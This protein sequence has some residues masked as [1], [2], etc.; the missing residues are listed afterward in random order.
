MADDG[1]WFEG[2]AIGEG[3]VPLKDIV[4]FLSSVNYKGYLSIEFEGIEW[5]SESFRL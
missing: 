1:T 5:L 3:S 4:N 2:T